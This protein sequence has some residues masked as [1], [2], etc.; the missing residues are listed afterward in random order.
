MVVAAAGFGTLSLSARR[1]GEY[2]ITALPYVTWRA[3]TGGGLVLLLFLGLVAAGRARVPALATVPGGQ[4]WALLAAGVCGAVTNLAAFSA[5]EL[6]TVAL[7]LIVFYTFPAIVTI[8]AVRLYGERIDG[9]RALALALS[10]AGLLLVVLAP[11]LGQSGIS[12]NLW[13][14]A[15]ALIAAVGQAAF[16]LI[17][18][19]GFSSVPSMLSTAVVM[20]SAGVIYV[21]LVLAAG[22]VSAVAIPFEVP[23]AWPWIVLTATVG[24][25]IPTMSLVSATR[26]IGPG[27]T[28][29]LMM[30]EPVVGVLLAGIFL[31]EH[32]SPWQLLGGVMVITAG[33]VLQLPARGRA[34]PVIAEA[35]VQTV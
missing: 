33:V 25:A 5:L 17:A 21:V 9:R 13:G 10:S 35:P 6:T 27:R 14:V 31:A 26:R 19:R 11:V 4:R 32:P 23:A 22:Q 24:A 15:L 16:L 8:G 34:A 12:V 7:M 18:G 20:L 28:S 30:L 3:V 1:L 29:I 2:D